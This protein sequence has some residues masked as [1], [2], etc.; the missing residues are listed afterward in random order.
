MLP[1]S[2][3]NNYISQLETVGPFNLLGKWIKVTKEENSPLFDFNTRTYLYNTEEVCGQNKLVP[4]NI[5]P[6]MEEGYDNDTVW[7]PSNNGQYKEFYSVEEQEQLKLQVSGM[8][9]YYFDII[10][11]NGLKHKTVE[12]YLRNQFFENKIVVIDEIHNFISMALPSSKKVCTKLYMEL[13]ATENVKIIGLSGTPIINTPYELAF[14]L[15]LLRGTMVEYQV[16]LDTKLVVSPSVV[17]KMLQALPFV[18]QARVLVKPSSVPQFYFTVNKNKF[19]ND[20]TSGLRYLK[21]DQTIPTYSLDN[22]RDKINSTK[23]TLPDGTEIPLKFI[24]PTKKNTKLLFPSQMEFEKLFIQETINNQ[25]IIESSLLNEK[26][27][28]RRMLGLISFLKPASKDYPD[29]TEMIIKTA[30]SRSQV[31]T[32]IKHRTEE[33][34]EETKLKK[35]KKIPSKIELDEIG[36]TKKKNN[37]TYRFATRSISNFAFPDEFKRIFQKKFLQ[38]ETKLNEKETVQDNEVDEEDNTNKNNP[39]KKLLHEEFAKHK[40]G[41]LKNLEKFLDNENADTLIHECSPKF[42]NIY[43]NLKKSPGK[44]LIYSFFKSIEGLGVFSI[45]L[46][47]KGWIEIKLKPTGKNNY[48]IDNF[49]EVSKEKYNNKRFILYTGELDNIQKNVMLDIFNF[50]K[51]KSKLN[52]SI[53]LQLT[54]LAENNFHGQIVNSLL[55]SLAGAEGINLKNVRQVHIVEPYWNPVKI[56]QVIGRA[57]RFKSHEELPTKD[58]N[59]TVYKY[60]SCFDDTTKLEN[61]VSSIGIT[62]NDGNQTTDEYV[63]QIMENKRKCNEAF[64]QAMKEVAFD[65]DANIVINQKNPENE[66]VRCFSPQEAE[67]VSTDYSYYPDINV[68]QHNIGET[69][70]TQKKLYNLNQPET[71]KKSSSSSSS[72]SEAKH[73][74][75]VEEDVY[76]DIEEELKDH[77]DTYELY[78]SLNDIVDFL[79]QI[80]DYKFDKEQISELSKVI[81][82]DFADYVLAKLETKKVR[83]VEDLI[84]IME[85]E[86]N[87]SL[88]K[89]LPYIRALYTYYKAHHKH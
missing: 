44:A 5:P 25:G 29:K 9:D 61:M 60:I 15:N 70:K 83:R 38:L 58:R 57:I 88:S 82:K 87:M 2:L 36:E 32:Y 43:E 63:F 59:V 53:L 86:K 8:I 41:L 80:Y 72:S 22:I 34:E 48:E 68:D 75:E 52:P 54:Q 13:L 6:I 85:S 30:M 66:K 67:Q 47:T 35:K 77:T 79:V 23:F 24:E 21:Y 45:I 14:L 62:E 78:Y 81:N 51:R 89:Q 27:L 26:I 42:S 4:L 18:D 74:A 49:K 76:K 39:F 19:T 40:Q 12:K 69:L 7:V 10:H 50:N 28:K 71:K 11:Y 64:I 46:K 84:P 56:E 73:P 17:S 31:S 3:R 20:F 65:C 37:G 33:I 16:K 1:A 55:V